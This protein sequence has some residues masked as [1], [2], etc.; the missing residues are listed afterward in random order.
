ME[1]AAIAN[2]LMYVI[3]AV[4]PTVIDQVYPLDIVRG[5]MTTTPG[6]YSG[7]FSGIATMVR[8]TAVIKSV[9]K[10]SLRSIC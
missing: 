4:H 5:R 2:S 6:L 7:M 8:T 9:Q 1:L 10:Q 3:P